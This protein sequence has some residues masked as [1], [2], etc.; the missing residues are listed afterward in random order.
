MNTLDSSLDRFGV[1]TLTLKRP[2]KRNALS[3]ELLKALLDQLNKA[4]HN[5]DVKIVLLQG[6]GSVFCSGLDLAEM[7][8]SHAMQQAG[9]FKDVLLKLHDLP[10]PVMV[11]AH[12]AAVGGGTGL[13]AAC[14]VVLAE[15]GLRFGFS[16]IRRG[17]V[18]VIVFP[19]FRR[20]LGDIKTKSL[21]FSGMTI[22]S[23]EMVQLGLATQSVPAINRRSVTKYWITQ[24]C[25]S[26]PYAIKLAKKNWNT[27]WASHL[28]FELEKALRMHEEILDQSDVQNSIFEFL[29]KNKPKIPIEN[30]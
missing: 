20:I 13:I 7:G 24:I 18:P 29:S 14:D 15:E 27:L 5:E 28:D 11:Y 30:T 12:G 6:E 25:G 10:K 26:H 17:L 16:E 21:L 8:S 3:I 9:F 2:E 19:F 1:L 4:T 22:G 23:L